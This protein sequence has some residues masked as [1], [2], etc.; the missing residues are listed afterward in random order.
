VGRIV[1][2]VYELQLDGKVGT[3]DEA[4]AEARRLVGSP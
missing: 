1:K 2:V 3:R 4:L